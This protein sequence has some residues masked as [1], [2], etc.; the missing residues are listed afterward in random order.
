MQ[1]T[2]WIICPICGGKTRI[3]V[4]ENTILLNCKKETILNFQ[5]NKISVII[6][7]THRRRADN[8]PD[9]SWNRLF[10]HTR[11]IKTWRFDGL[12]FMPKYLKHPSKPVKFGGILC[13]LF[14]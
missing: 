10:F 3:Q 5:K 13:F 6:D 11:R 4:R 7:S 12:F 8:H 14:V 2:K 1:E 9:I